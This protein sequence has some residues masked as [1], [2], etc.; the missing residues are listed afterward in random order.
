MRL[1]AAAIACAAIASAGGLSDERASKAFCSAAL[2]RSTK[3]VEIHISNGVDIDYPCPT[4]TGTMTAL[5]F[6]SQYGYTDLAN[7]LLYWG[8]DANAKDSKGFHAL[9]RAAE[10]GHGEIVRILLDVVD[11]LNAIRNPGGFSPLYK[12]AREGNIAAL[13][14]LLEDGR[15][16]FDGRTEKGITPLFAAAAEGRFACVAALLRS[17]ADASIT[18]KDGLLPVD[19]A[20]RNGHDEVATI[21][22]EAEGWTPSDRFCAAAYS[23]D[24]TTVESSIRSGGV[25]VD[26]LCGLER[27]R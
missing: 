12:A 4:S 9:Y 27:R 20:S 21:L 13:E 1:L 10:H 22:K 8:A 14:I 17:G 23:G 7:Y 25:D 19:V 6:A 5:H 3:A 15:L 2:L 26:A 24:V 16:P 11:P 18:N